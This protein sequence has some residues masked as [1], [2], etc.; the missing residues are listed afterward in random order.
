LCKQA[1]G[2]KQVKKNPKRGWEG[3]PGYSKTELQSPVTKAGKN[4][5]KEVGTQDKKWQSPA[6]GL[7][8]GEKTR[9]AEVPNGLGLLNSASGGGAGKKG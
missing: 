9:V 2:R 6:A 4:N 5:N 7:V 3:I 8:V 1:G